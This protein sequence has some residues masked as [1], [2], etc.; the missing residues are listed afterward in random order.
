MI[1]LVTGNLLQADVEALVNTVNT[2]GAMGK[3][4]AL[5]FKQAYPANFEA[6]R[7]AVARGE[8]QPGRMF[9]FETGLMMNPRVIINFPTKRHWRGRSRIE[10]IQSGLEDLARVIE[11]RGI[12]SIAIP[13]L[14]CGNGGLDWDDVRPLILA[15]LKRVPEVRALVFGPE[16]P[17]DPGSMPVG[18]E[19]PRMTPARALLVRLMDRYSELAYRLTLLEIQ[20]LAYFLQESGE[21]L[22]LEFEKGHYGPYA[23][24]LNKV[25]ERI[26]G[27]FTRG[28]GDTQKPDVEIRLLPGANEEAIEFLDALP[29]SIARLD[30]VAS[31]IDGFETPYGMELLSSVHWVAAR[32]PKVRDAAGAIG[33]VHGWSD[34]KQSMFKAH[35]IEVAWNRLAEA[36]W[37][38][39]TGGSHDRLQKPR[40]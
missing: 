16:G 4:I 6:Y 28:Y 8:V 12:R 31:L 33:A 15:M 35:H 20:K 34:R 2:V 1:E 38:P 23:A 9:V 25:L 37:V 36:G 17:P 3:G 26:E 39:V 30:A 40:G 27:H 7:K 24:N 18:T 32:E 19:R 14:G 11:T 29:E 10:D 22:R 13:P 5:Q 21:P